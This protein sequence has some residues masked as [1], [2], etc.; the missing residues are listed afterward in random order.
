M[1]WRV[2]CALREVMLIFWPTSALSS[3]DLPTLGL[4]TMATRPQRGRRVGSWSAGRPVWSLARFSASSMQHGGRCACS[5]GAARAPMPRSR[6]AEL[7]DLALDVEGLLV[8]RPARR[9]R[10]GTPAAASCAPAAIPAVRSS[11]SL[12][13]AGDVGLISMTSPNRRRTSASRRVD[14]RRRGRPRRSAP[15]ARRPGSRAR[16][17]PPERASPSPRRSTSGRPRSS[18]SWCSVSCLHQVR[19]HARQVAFVGAG[20]SARTAGSTTARFRTES[21]RNSS[22]SLWSAREAA[23]RQRPREQPRIREAVLQALPADASEA[24]HATVVERSSLRHLVIASCAHVL[25][26]AGTPGRT[27][28]I[29]LS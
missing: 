14:S 15:R 19:A 9:R 25:D 18:A 13:A 3:V 17:A 11:A 20:R 23:V 12:A 22:R 27:C 16:C 24:G 10:R 28:G 2:V 29:S 6:Q 7:G 26:A 5:A 4:P 21:P 8:R 1:R